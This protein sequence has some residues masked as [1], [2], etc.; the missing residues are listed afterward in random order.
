LLSRAIHLDISPDLT[1]ENIEELAEAY[2]KV[3]ENLL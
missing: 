1:S 3:L 2:N